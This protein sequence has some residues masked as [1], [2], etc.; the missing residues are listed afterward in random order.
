MAV[1][2]SKVGNFEYP[3][4]EGAARFVK[5]P[6][7]AQCMRCGQAK[8][9]TTSGKYST[10]AGR[11]HQQ[12]TNGLVEL[13]KVLL[14]ENTRKHFSDNLSSPIFFAPFLTR[15]EPHA[16]LP[17]NYHKLKLAR[18]AGEDAGR[19]HTAVI[20]LEAKL[21]GFYLS[22]PLFGRVFKEVLDRELR[23]IRGIGVHEKKPSIIGE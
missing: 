11:F 8:M 14:S 1:R 15:K 19:K 23:S 4:A 22:A 17:H 7:T 5:E 9:I 18:P 10:G 3:A 12:W 6:R 20:L 13:E 2:T 16:H 21:S